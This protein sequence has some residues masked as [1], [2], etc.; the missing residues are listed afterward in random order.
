MQLSLRS[1]RKR[2]RET[3]TAR[4]L[5]A[6][7]FKRYENKEP[8]IRKRCREQAKTK[9]F[10][11][12]KLLKGTNNEGKKKKQ[13]QHN[14]KSSKT[15]REHATLIIT[16][17]KRYAYMQRASVNAIAF[18]R[19]CNLLSMAS[20][21]LFRSFFLTRRSVGVRAWHLFYVFCSLRALYFNCELN[22]RK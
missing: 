1:E 7:L 20:S 9:I 3:A 16:H 21:F 6:V 11:V 4:D 8:R 5:P 10:T 15:D 22:R 2:A 14:A 18:D 12:G 13:Q 19:K 17:R